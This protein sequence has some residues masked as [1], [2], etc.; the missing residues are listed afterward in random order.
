M[1]KNNEES[2]DRTEAEKSPVVWLTV[3]EAAVRRG[4]VAL[5]NRA[6]GELAKRGVVI[7]PAGV[8]P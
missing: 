5:A 8:S 6:R 3:Y 2:K 7:Q 4:D 1:T